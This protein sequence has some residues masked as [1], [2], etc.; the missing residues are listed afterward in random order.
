[1]KKTIAHRLAQIALVIIAFVATCTF[2]S[3]AALSQCNGPNCPV[4]TM[5]VS[6]LLGN[7]CVPLAFRCNNGFTSPTVSYCPGSHTIPCPCPAATGGIA[8]VVVGGVLIPV[9]ATVNVPVGACCFKVAVI[10][11]SGSGCI[12]LR[13]TRC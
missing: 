7:C 1:M 8:G 2:G 6:T 12:V 10:Q 5:T 9:G 11:S 13:V 4:V 3:T